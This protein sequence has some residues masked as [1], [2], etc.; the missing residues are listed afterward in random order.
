MPEPIILYR[1]VI[2][3]GKVAV[4]EW[5]VRNTMDY[6]YVVVQKNGNN[7][8]VAKTLDATD[9][10]SI[11][12]GLTP[13]SAVTSLA[14]GRELIFERAHRRAVRAQDKMNIA[15]QWLRENGGENEGNH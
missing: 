9:G 2:R 4:E 15:D 10:F 8:Y 1:A 7:H 12:F 3:R 11:G 14:N 6:W 5:N 13:Y